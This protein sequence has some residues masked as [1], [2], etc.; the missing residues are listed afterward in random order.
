MTDID[1]WRRLEEQKTQ[2]E[3][4]ASPDDVSMTQSSLVNDGSSEAAAAQ[5]P[6]QGEANPAFVADGGT[7][8]TFK[9][10]N[11]PTSANQ[12]NVKS[13]PGYGLVGYMPL[14]GD[15]D[16]EYDQ[17]AEQILADLEFSDSDE[18]SEKQLK[19]DVIAI[20][21][22][23]LDERQRRKNFVVDRKLLDYKRIQ[24]EERRRPVAER[25]LVARMRVLS[26]FHSQEEHDALVENVLAAKRLRSRIEKLQGYQKLGLRNLSDVA[27]YEDK[28]ERKKEML[29]GGTA[30]E[31]GDGNGGWS[32]ISSGMSG[33]S[34]SKRH[35]PWSSEIEG[36]GGGSDAS[37]ADMNS[38]PGEDLLSEKEKELCGA[39]GLL[40]Q[41]YLVTKA[42][43][44]KE[45]VA[46]GFVDRG[47]AR[48]L[49]RLDVKQVD[50]A[51]DFF[52]SRGWI[53][54]GPPPDTIQS[55]NT[56][57]TVMTPMETL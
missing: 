14:R 52:V 6:D 17:D 12:R 48:R 30:F 46:Q 57:E 33:G 40:P 44:V 54:S 13:L 7:R 18:P 47:S 11:S 1:N 16:T 23:R 20:Y 35:R 28:K 15:F 51:F 24:M 5:G 27:A 32:N 38:A 49:V 53:S 55:E 26:Q 31:G 50:S 21:N 41:Q 37:A 25:E 56:S 34:I 10:K 19:L 42:A 45:S 39:L 43:I 22:K 2:S 36:W 3:R 29:R 4:P 9:E 8:T